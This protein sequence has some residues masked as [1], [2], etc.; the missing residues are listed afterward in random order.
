MYLF[1]LLTEVLYLSLLKEIIDTERILCTVLILLD[2]ALLKYVRKVGRID[3]NELNYYNDSDCILKAGIIIFN[4]R[5]VLLLIKQKIWI[6]QNAISGFNNIYN[7]AYLPYKVLLDVR[8]LKIS[9]VLCVL[10]LDNVILSKEFLHVEV[11]CKVKIVSYYISDTVNVKVTNYDV[12][13]VLI[14]VA[15]C[16][17]LSLCKSLWLR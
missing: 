7:P 2:E 16:L 17:N 6:Q 4:L 15:Y 13:S 5:V 10:H 11:E 8:N 12:Q 9:L 1:S 14:S 3:F